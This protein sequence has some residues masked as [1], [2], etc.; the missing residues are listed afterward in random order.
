M[1]HERKERVARWMRN[2]PGLGDNKKFA[3][4][5]IRERVWYGAEIG[6]QQHDETR[7]HPTIGVSCSFEVR[8]RRLAVFEVGHQGLRRVSSDVLA[9]DEHRCGTMQPIV[10]SRKIINDFVRLLMRPLRLF[11]RVRAVHGV[12]CAT[13]A[14][15]LACVLMNGCARRAPTDPQLVAVWVRTLYGA[16]RVERLSPPVA[17]RLTTYAV[18]ALYAGIAAVDT[19]LPALDSTLRGIPHLPRADRPWELDGTLV[20]IAAER[21]VLD[22]LLKE[23]LPTTRAAFVRLADSLLTDRVRHGVSD[24]AQARSDALGA[25]IGLLIVAWSRA[26]GFAGTRGRPYAPSVGVGAWINDAPANT[27]ATQNLSGASEFVSL[28]NPANQQRTGNMS[29]RG[30]ILSRP[31]AATLSAL[32]AANMAG[33]TEPYWRE[34]RPFV[35]HS[36]DACAVTPAPPYSLDT[37]S[38]LYHDARAVYDTKAALTAEQRTIAYYWADNAG[39]S[40]TPVGHWLSIAS[41]IISERHLDAATAVRVVLATAVAQA[42]AFV[43]AWGYKY[44]YGHLR[45]RT[46]IRRVIDATWEPLIPTPPF[47]ERPAGHSTQSAAAAAVLTAFIGAVPFTDSTSI[48]IGHTVR[49]FASFQAASEEAGMS[50]VYGGIHYPSGNTSGLALGRCVGAKVAA[51]FGATTVNQRSTR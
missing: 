6:R 23:A 50:R 4:I 25:R 45:P 11:N 26:D 18:T 44:L 5:S 29:D 39:E 12:G 47:P 30:L 28:D 40:G 38:A 19:I 34:V 14:C 21:T 3:G 24:V 32:P 1:T 13:T 33:A 16:I 15:A 35:L 2:A 46:Y 37:S 9:W 17:S 51:A 49:Y 41:Q 36:W 10:R 20:A 22:S 8:L 42:D 31:K 27:Y 48:S 7:E 43:A